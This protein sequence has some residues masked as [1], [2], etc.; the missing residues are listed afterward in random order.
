MKAFGL[1]LIYDLFVFEPKDG[2]TVPF[3]DN[4]WKRMMPYRNPQLAASLMDIF[5]TEREYEAQKDKC[6]TILNALIE[7]RRSALKDSPYE[8]FRNFEQ[9]KLKIYFQHDGDDAK[10]ERDLGVFLS[11][12][13]QEEKQLRAR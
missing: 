5:F 3:A 10:A 8:F 7:E 9:T 4:D 1:G 6:I 2:W 12:L 11:Y 13:L